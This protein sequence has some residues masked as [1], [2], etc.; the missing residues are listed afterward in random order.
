MS[1]KKEYRSCFGCTHNRALPDKHPCSRCKGASK[2]KKLTEPQLK[3][4]RAKQVALEKYME[5][6][7]NTAQFETKGLSKAF[8]N[9]S[10]KGELD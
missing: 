10:E 2:W 1:E 7:S 6:T 3:K 8:K 4:A 9:K 5:K